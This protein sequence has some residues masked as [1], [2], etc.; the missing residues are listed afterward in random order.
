[1]TELSDPTLQLSGAIKWT[2]SYIKQ[3]KNKLVCLDVCNF[4]TFFKTL[5]EFERDFVENLPVIC[6][7]CACA[8]SVLIYLERMSDVQLADI[9]L[10]TQSWLVRTT[11]LLFSDLIHCS[12]WTVPQVK[13]VKDICSRLS[14][15]TQI[16]LQSTKRCGSINIWTQT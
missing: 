9:Q 16:P 2:S 3:L 12:L 4:M 7:T 5:F 8:S 13:Y 6:N 11:E 1:M 14:K 10:M 15:V